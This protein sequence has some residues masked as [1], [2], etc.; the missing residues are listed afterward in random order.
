MRQV[1]CSLGS[2][3]ER[4]LYAL[5]NTLSCLPLTN[6]GEYNGPLV[7]GRGSIPGMSKHKAVKATV[8]TDFRNGAEGLRAFSDSLYSLTW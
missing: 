1:V 2:K 5:F 7:A 8:C 6:E 4:A 3:M